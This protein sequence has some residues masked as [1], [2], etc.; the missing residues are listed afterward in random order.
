[1][2]AIV[3]RLPMRDPA[4]LSALKA[5]FSTG[6]LD[7]HGIVAILAKTEGNGGDRPCT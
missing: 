6:R 7:P 1:M 2:K 5:A 4:D 3:E